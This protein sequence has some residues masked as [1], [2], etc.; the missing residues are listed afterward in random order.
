MLEVQISMRGPWPEHGSLEYID[1]TK[2]YG[3]SS[4][5]RLV[6]DPDR[7]LADDNEL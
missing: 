5:G 1:G 4:N 6:M 7:P 2:Y 3:H